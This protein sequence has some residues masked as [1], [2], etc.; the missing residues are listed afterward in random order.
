MPAVVAGA[1][2]LLRAHRVELEQRVGAELV[3]TPDLRRI[4]MLGG[5]NVTHPQ[6]LPPRVAVAEG[7]AAAVDHLIRFGGDAQL[8]IDRALRGGFDRRQQDVAAERAQD[9]QRQKQQM[10]SYFHR[11]SP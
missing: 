10:Y 11:R 3:G 5:K 4:Q 9:E 6:R 1:V 7:E 8:Q 2:V